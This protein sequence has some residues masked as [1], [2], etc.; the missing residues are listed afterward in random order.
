MLPHP[1]Y[2]LDGDGYVGNKDFVIAKHFDDGNKGYL[3]E[4]EK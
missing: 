4:E 3:K 2:D 1:S